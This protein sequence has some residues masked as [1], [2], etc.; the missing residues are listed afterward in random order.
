MIVAFWAYTTAHDDVQYAA[1]VNGESIEACRLIALKQIEALIAE[2]SP[3]VS[4]KGFYPGY[5][6]VQGLR[7]LHDIVRANPPT[8]LEQPGVLII[9]L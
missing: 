2:K 6:A 9:G 8:T 4:K 7:E 5:W 1:L 3:P